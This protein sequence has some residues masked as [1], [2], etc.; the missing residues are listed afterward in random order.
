[1]DGAPLYQQI[2][3]D[4]FTAAICSNQCHEFFTLSCTGM[5]VVFVFNLALIVHDMC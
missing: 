5:H 3:N 2:A 4:G 1:M